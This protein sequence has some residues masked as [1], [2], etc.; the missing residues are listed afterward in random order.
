VIRMGRSLAAGLAWALPAMCLTL[1]G[2]GRSAAAPYDHDVHTAE[3]LRARDGLPNVLAKAAGGGVV[4]VAYV[5]GSITAAAGW[6]PKTLAWLSEQY[7]GATFEEIDAAISGTGSDYGACRLREDVLRFDPDLVFLEFRV[8]GGGGYEAKSMEGIV[9][10]IWGANPA[11]DIC[12]VYTVCEP[13]LP[14]VR[15]GQTAGFGTI[16]EGIANRYGIPTIEL[17]LEVV[18]QEAA[19][20]LVF[21]AGSAPGGKL[22]FSSDGVHPT[23][24]GHDL[25]RDVIA[26]SIVAMETVGTP[27]PHEMGEP[28]DPGA[29]VTATML[30]VDQAALSDGWAPVDMASDPVTSA[31]R[32]RTEGMLRGARR[33]DRVGESVTV[34]F[35]GTGVAF[36]DVPS[37][38]PITVEAVIDGG[39]PVTLSR[40]SSEATR[41][42]ARY[43]WTPELPAGEHTVTFTVRTLPEGI[44]FYTGQ[45]WIVGEPL[46]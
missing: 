4:R 28:L 31:D 7:P 6:R 37:V 29:W 10:Q 36:T 3:E 46:R 21:R 30:P 26:R 15:A 40:A 43:W 5:G 41:L 1:V 33:C 24:A 13:M 11:T 12:F 16:M 8:N 39:E 18:R 38:E 32:G 20:A 45:F 44:P 14:T 23:D 9:R 19:R 2:A 17:G 34:R 42:Y 22:L 27:G 25:Y 35:R